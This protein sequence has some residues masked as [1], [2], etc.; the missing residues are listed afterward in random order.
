MMAT[1][2]DYEPVLTFRPIADSADQPF[3]LT[4]LDGDHFRAA[5]LDRSW[6]AVFTRQP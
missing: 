2:D 6:R 3:S 5:A 4:L 1:L